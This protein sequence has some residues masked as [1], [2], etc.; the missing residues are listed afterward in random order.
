MRRSLLVL[1]IVGM[2]VGVLAAPV[3][4]RGNGNPHGQPTIYVTSQ[5]L[6]YDSIVL[7]EI[8]DVEGAPYQTL[9]FGGPT[10]LRTE[11]GPGDVGYVGGR[12]WVDDGEVEGVMEETDTFFICPLLGPGHAP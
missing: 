6:V 10:G 4:A 11:F 9:E 3:S 7:T 2:L 8:P 12:W 1:A 5:D